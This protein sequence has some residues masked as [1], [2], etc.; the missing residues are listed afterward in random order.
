MTA[1][2]LKRSYPF[3]LDLIIKCH[4]WPDDVRV[5]L[6]VVV[7]VTI[8]EV[9]VPGVGAIVLLRSPVVGAR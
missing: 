6:V 1:A 2:I 3:L 4:D 8:A 5:I 7:D 9:D